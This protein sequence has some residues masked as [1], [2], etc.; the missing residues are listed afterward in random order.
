[1][2]RLKQIDLYGF[3]SFCNREQLRFSGSGIAA[4][5]G[6]N[7][8]GKS[9]ICDAINWVL[10]EQSAKSLR[11]SRMHD[12]IFSGTNR[13]NPAGMA[14]V[15]LTLHDPDATLKS[16][17]QGNGRTRP[18]Q[19]PLGKT[20]GE[21]TVARKLFSSGESHYILN[22]KVVRL[23]DVQDLFLGTGLGPNHYAI[24]EQGRIGQLLSSR[25]LDRRAFVE[26]AA[27]VTRFKARR[28]L[29]ELKLVNAN[30][31]LERVHDILREIQ[32]QADSLKRQA[33]RAE[34]YELYREQLRAAQRL[35]FASRFRHI[36][37]DRIRLE[38]EVEAGEAR[39]REVSAETERMEFE[40]SEKRDL[41]QR[42]ET[43]LETEREELSDLRIDEE[44]IRERVEQQSRAAADSTVRWR[45]AAQD[46]QTVSGRLEELKH[47]VDS[48]R[49]NVAAIAQGADQLRQRLGNK[50]LECTVQE[51][52]MADLQAREEVCRRR[53]LETLNAISHA[54]EHLGKL[55][56]AL[57]TQEHQLER[58]RARMGDASEQ[59]D[60]AAEQRRQQGS[61]AAVLRGELADKAVRRETLQAALAERR[62]QFEAVRGQ[63]DNQRAEFSRLTARRDSLREMLA[64][65]AFTTEA[66]QDIFDA[67]EKSPHADFRP[68]GIL[69][70]FL[71]VEEGYEKLVE[72]FLGEELEYVVVGAW[73]EAGR[74]V[75]LVREEFEGR[76]AF[77]VQSG[78]D[79]ATGGFGPEPEHGDAERLMD[80]VRL[81]PRKAEAPPGMLPKLRDGYLV[82]DAFTA[83]RLAALHP[84]RYFLL[85]DGTWYRGNTVQIGRKASS[86]PL[87][88]KQQLRD[89]IPEL[90]ET[91]RGLGQL[92][93]DI[94]S[95]EDAVQRDS[96]ELETVRG[97]LQDLEKQA[98][99]VEHDLRQT[100]QR[101]GDL[102]ATLLAAGQEAKRLEGEQARC[103]T[104][105]N[106]VISERARLDL[107]YAQ[108][109]A[110]SAELSA[111][112]R[113]CQAL[114][115]RL[116]EERTTLRTEAAALEERRRAGEA[117][118]ARVEALLTEQRQRSSD[119]QRQIAQWQLESRRLLQ[120]NEGLED[121]IA[122][123]VERQKGLRQRIA[124]TTENLRELRT[125]MR[126]LVEA[127][128]EQRSHVE[129][130]RR[131]CSTKEVELARAQ[132][133]LEHLVESCTAELGEPI[134]A[135]AGRAPKDLTPEALREAE[136]QHRSVK[137]KI[138]RLGPVNV[139]AREEYEQ[140]A[141]RLHFLESQQQ[142]LLD[143]IRNTRQ[144]IREID[145]ASRE[146]FD[147]AFEG[148]NGNFRQVFATLFGG[149]LGEM[150]LTDPEKT[151][152]SGIDIVAQP[153]G[154]RLQNVALLSGGEKSL[155]VMAL[156][157]AT[158]RYKPSPFC[159]L[160]EVDSQLDEANTVRF[161]RLLQDMA[162]ET[163][164]ILITHS[165]T[166]ME[167]AETLYG[168]TM[169]EAGVS[170]LV[171]VR[172]ANSQA[173]AMPQESFVEEPMALSA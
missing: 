137:E 58:E 133:D 128:R 7:G 85:P 69:A 123:G 168:V 124:A 96:A 140:V 155:T 76:A 77:V 2:L 125:Q 57:A 122:H 114:L 81:V 46:L 87:V 163:Q 48:E 101:I 119:A 97:G 170:K 52:A 71:E 107:V 37:S 18:T 135:I 42:W 103:A 167:V 106:Q 102:Q 162:P 67:I 1:M 36:D 25:P 84:E 154:K 93:L 34:R 95:A 127:V 160:D 111:Q 26:E 131:E 74:G 3:K 65:R 83:Q 169:S 157:M 129:A 23:R 164:F 110:R 120:D 173:V 15:T 50:E 55:D 47:G 89:L 22:G 32:R 143:S 45:Q 139:L 62:R 105:R 4:I 118:L 151:E 159:I 66:V 109:E 113:E 53:L 44:R 108:T 82:E 75:Q 145:A 94:E 38:A 153:P 10:G 61:Q 19:V 116:Q 152:E 166:T 51:A 149:G 28:K 99:A 21:I 11:G 115:A 29:A 172:M 156:L 92:D 68:L 8:C 79:L 136:E 91:E 6:P 35:L 158:F 78:P 148:I 41:E 49:Q 54:R 12:V 64:H 121:R 161:R 70:D 24:I 73:G 59:L 43:Q 141:Q 147:K 130:A 134:S 90:Q 165:K 30:L 86:G 39:L 142:D 171:S 14:T 98:L 16:L 126:A 27:G 5:V 31:N 20:P 56:E 88:L 100:G 9:N 132:A 80:H 146:K 17:F 144:A 72:Q 138:E 104:Q 112:S 63:A 13:R 40:F 33:A 150:R 60:Q 117:S